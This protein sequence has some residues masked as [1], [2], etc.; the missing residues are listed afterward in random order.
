MYF[1][2]KPIRTFAMQTS[3]LATSI[4][5]LAYISS[6][7]VCTFYNLELR[8][9]S[10]IIKFASYASCILS[11]DF[12][13]FYLIL[14]QAHIIEFPKAEYFLFSLFY[15]LP[16]EILHDAFNSHI[17]RDDVNSAMTYSIG[18]QHQSNA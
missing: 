15:V 3:F 9:E 18:I 17:W 4:N 2:L 11:F 12:S 16:L 6:F 14:L 7:V 8:C 10:T 5:I 1:L 13:F